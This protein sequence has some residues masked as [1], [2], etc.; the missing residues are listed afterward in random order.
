MGVS[1]PPITG[2]VTS[3]SA[4]NEAL[5]LKPKAS[6]AVSASMAFFKAAVAVAVSMD[7]AVTL[8]PPHEAS[9]NKDETTRMILFF[10]M[11]K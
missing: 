6:L 11:N 1:M 9:K 7:E 3:K 2:V 5:A 8:L 4:E 10:M